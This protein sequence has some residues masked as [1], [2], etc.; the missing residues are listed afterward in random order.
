MG[1]YQLGWLDRIP[2]R[3]AVHESVEL[4]KRAR[5]RSAAPFVNAIL[6]KLSN[7]Q[8]LRGVR[9]NSIESE[10]T[11]EAIASH[12]AHPEWIVTR[13]SSHFGIDATQRICAFD[14]SVPTTAIRL[15]TD[16]VEEELQKDEIV[17][18]PGALLG[19]AR[20]V[21]SG[22][23]SRTKAWAQGCIAIQDEASQL[24]SMLLG[25]GNRIL[26]CCAAPGGKAWA[27]AD[28]NPAASIVAVELH[29]HRAEIVRKRVFAPNL[30]VITAD[31]REVSFET[32]FDHVLVDVPC[33]GTGTLARNPEIKWRLKLEDLAALRQRQVAILRAGMRHTA[34]GGTLLYSTCSLEFEEDESVVEEVLRS[35]QTFRLQDVGPCLERLR[36]EGELVENRVASLSSGPYFRTVPGVQLCDGFFGALLEKQRS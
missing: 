5:K 1:V 17:L 18:A 30:T 9:S 10:K 36:V 22:D 15:R 35:D 34:P 4:V 33:S 2:V 20:R 12:L 29:P 3:A 25:K 19:R 21:I 8:I 23:L 11:T 14:Q 31:I 24:V 7:S 27:I 13:W 28:R 6:R 32:K 26:D 16:S